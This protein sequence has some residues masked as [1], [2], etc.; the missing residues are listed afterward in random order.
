[1]FSSDHDDPC[2]KLVLQC[3]LKNTRKEILDVGVDFDT[4]N[5]KVG[6]HPTV[7]FNMKL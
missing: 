6:A 5:M 2:L 1:M 7:P 3:S 4:I